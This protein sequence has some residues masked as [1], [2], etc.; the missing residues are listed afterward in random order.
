MIKN[1]GCPISTENG[2]NNCKK[3]E[4][5]ASVTIIHSDRYF[6]NTFWLLIM[7]LVDLVGCIEKSILFYFLTP[8]VH[9]NSLFQIML[10]DFWC[11]FY[12]L[13]PWSIENII[14][15]YGVQSIT[16]HNNR[17]K[18]GVKSI[19]SNNGSFFSG[20]LYANLC[21]IWKRWYFRARV[22]VGYS[23]PAI[24]SCAQT[25]G[26]L[27]AQGHPS[28]REASTWSWKLGNIKTRVVARKKGTLQINGPRFSEERCQL[29]R[30]FV[31]NPRLRHQEHVIYLTRIPAKKGTRAGGYREHRLWGALAEIY[32]C[33]IPFLHLDS[34]LV[35]RFLVPSKRP[36]VGTD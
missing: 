21:L 3:Y 33:G 18:D 7:F 10:C 12:Q 8:T 11:C 5:F 1:T 9:R 30:D 32:S 2:Q 14:W 29:F 4:T 34:E 19:T 17:V 15:D 20:R 27:V 23:V 13:S 22:K 6:N 28:S 35:E 16:S 25:G 36:L 26:Q 24:F 31:T